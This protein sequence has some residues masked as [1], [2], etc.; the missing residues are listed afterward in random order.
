M[1]SF[2]GGDRLVCER[3]FV[4]GSK[5]PVPC[6]F[7]SVARSDRCFAGSIIHLRRYTGSSADSARQTRSQVKLGGSTSTDYRQKSRSRHHHCFGSHRQYSCTPADAGHNP[8]PTQ[9]RRCSSYSTPGRGLAGAVVEGPLQCHSWHSR[10]QHPAGYSR[11]ALFQRRLS[12]LCQQPAAPT[13][14][15]GL[16]WT[17]RLRYAQIR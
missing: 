7:K 6:N 15:S 16:H 17:K 4:Y 3:G 10:K 5:L 1:P 2:L 14:G 12:Q 9:G 13:P 8:G 11:S